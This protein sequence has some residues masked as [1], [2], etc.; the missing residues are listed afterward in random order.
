MKTKLASIQCTPFAIKINTLAQIR[1]SSILRSSQTQNES[2]PYSDQSS[3]KINFDRNHEIHQR[4]RKLTELIEAQEKRYGSFDEGLN[5]NINSKLLQ[6]KEEN[7][8][9]PQIVKRK[10][11]RKIFGNSLIM[12][13][14]R[15]NS[16]NQTY[17][18]N[19]RQMMNC[20]LYNKL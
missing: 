1:T 2:L 13:T 14:S 7:V 4:S 6:R 8:E 18:R 16:L 5:S 9:D 15:K 20:I 3:F 17:I 10:K 12:K 11:R 19:E